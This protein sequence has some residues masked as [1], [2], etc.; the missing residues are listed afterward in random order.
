MTVNAAEHQPGAATSATGAGLQDPARTQYMAGY[1]C[2]KPPPL[3]FAKAGKALWRLRR[4][5][6][7]LSD[8][9]DVTDSLAG[10][11]LAKFFERF[12]KTPYGKRVVDT[13]IRLEEILSDYDHLASLPAGSLGRGY[14]AYMESTG[15]MPEGIKTVGEGKGY[16]LNTDRYAAYTRFFCHLGALHDIWH[17][18]LGYGRDALGEGCLLTVTREVSG[19]NAWYAIVAGGMVVMKSQRPDLPIIKAIHEARRIGRTCGPI[20]LI[21]VE[22]WLARPL[23]DL[24]AEYKIRL[25]ETYLG[26]SEENRA[27]LMRPVATAA[28]KAAAA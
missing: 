11:S 4:N 18:L 22:H 23:D 8:V 27:G 6:D 9:F 24:R 7:N 12:V 16:D 17:V 1:P 28:D 20:H 14:L 3:D 26:I 10:N 13:P 21:D 25:P 19:N 15:F 5:K 2:P